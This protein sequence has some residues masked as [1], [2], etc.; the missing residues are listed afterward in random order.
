[1]WDNK[2]NCGRSAKYFLPDGKSSRNKYEV[3]QSY[4][5]LASELKSL[6]QNFNELLEAAESLRFFREGT[7]YYKEAEAVVL[8]FKG[9]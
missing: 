8:K 3:C 2:C 4:D 7:D 5:D 1:M 6:K 9:E